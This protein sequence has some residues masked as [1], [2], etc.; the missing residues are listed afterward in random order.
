M[1]YGPRDRRREASDLFLRLT[2]W[3]G[4]GRR[5]N[6]DASGALLTR[7]LN[8]LADALAKITADPLSM[9]RIDKATAHLSIA[10]PLR[11]TE[12]QTK[13]WV[14]K[15]FDT[16]PDPAARIE[17]LREVGVQR[18]AR[19]AVSMP[20]AISACDCQALRRSDA[21]PCPKECE[22]TVRRAI[23]TWSRPSSWRARPSCRRY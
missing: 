1:L 16:H 18:R 13:G 2:F 4:D 10:S 11:D 8:G 5:R 12:G 7:N 6:N 9:R 17:K 19:R 14:T 22:G 20:P 15:L 3:F 21:D 23:H